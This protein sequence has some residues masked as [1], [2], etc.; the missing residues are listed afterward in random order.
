MPV[1]EDGK[2]VGYVNVIQKKAFKWVNKEAIAADVPDY[3]AEYL[4][5]YHNTLI[6]AVAETS[7]E[8]MDRFLRRRVLGGGDS[9]GS[10]SVH[11]GRHH[12]SG[13]DGLRTCSS[14]RLHDDG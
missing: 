8:F 10:T 13:R 9:C 2:L 12:R 3:S 4:E 11:S 14:W 7:E 1:R 5:Q 6:E